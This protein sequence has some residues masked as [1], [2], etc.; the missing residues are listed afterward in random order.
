MLYDLHAK[1]TS[2]R[3]LRN[4]LRSLRLKTPGMK[5][6]KNESTLKMDFRGG[7]RCK[8][9]YKIFHEWYDSDFSNP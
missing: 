7:A 1:T 5:R 9:I 2:L 3:P 4:P 6:M 8:V